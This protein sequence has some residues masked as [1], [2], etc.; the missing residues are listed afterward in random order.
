MKKMMMVTL[1]ALMMSFSATAQEEVKKRPEGMKMDRTEMLKHRTAQVVEKYGLDEKQAE[2]LLELNT[3]FSEKMGHRMHGMR[4]GGPQGRMNRM[5]KPDMQKADK[6]N[7]D[8]Q[9]ENKMGNMEEMRQKMEET[10]KEYDEQLKQIMTEEQ[11]KAYKADE[12]NRPQRG[13][14]GPRPQK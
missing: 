2:Q 14:R 3:K 13:P 11:F 9:K 1:T 6:E 12:Q 7:P 10:R 5:Q 4:P 8:M